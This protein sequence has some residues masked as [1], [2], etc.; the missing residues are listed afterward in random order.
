MVFFL[1][2]EATEA[3]KWLRATGFPQY[4]QMYEGTN[5]LSFIPNPF[6]VYIFHLLKNRYAISHSNITSRSR[7]SL[8][9]KRCFALPLSETQDSQQLRSLAPA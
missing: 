2:I 5:K 6:T 7:P 8:P 1:E 3:C 9:G 4:A